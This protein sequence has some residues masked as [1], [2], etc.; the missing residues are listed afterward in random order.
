MLFILVC[1]YFPFNNAKESDTMYTEIIKKDF[2]KFWAKH[3]KA[4]TLKLKV[5]D[6]LKELIE[7][8]IAYNPKERYDLER[9]KR[10]KFYQESMLDDKQY[11]KDMETKWNIVAAP[12]NDTTICSS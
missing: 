11:V 3:E 4:S 7:G 2:K 9:V 1:G 10:S 8:M 6:N 5:S 12:L